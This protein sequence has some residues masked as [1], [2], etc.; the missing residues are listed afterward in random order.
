MVETDNRQ[1]ADGRHA[2]LLIVDD[3][4]AN[5]Q[6]LRVTLE[7]KGF[8]VTG[9]TDPD[10]ALEAITLGAFD[11]LLT[12]LKMP[13]TTGVELLQRAHERDPYLAGIVMTGEGSIASAVE[14]MRSGAVDYVLK[15]LKLSNLLPV[16]A[17]AL[18]LGRLRRENGQLEQSVRARTA[19]LERALEEVDRQAAERLK[20][21]QALMQAQKI[22]A[23]GRLT[24]GVAHDFNNLLA[25]VIGNLELLQRK[26]EPEAPY[27]RFVDNALEAANRGAKVTG[28]L[29]AFSRTQRLRLEPLE[30]DATLQRS[31]PLLRQA[32]GPGVD[33]EVELEAQGAWADTDATQ[34]ELAALNLIVNAREAL[35]EGGVVRLST[36]LQ[37]DWIV[38][39]V[40]DTGVGMTPEV[41]ARAT[42]PFFTTRTGSGTG[43][44]LAQVH[45]FARQCGGD[46]EI[47]SAPGA[48]TRV[49]ISLPRGSAPALI[50]EP[51]PPPIAIRREGLKVLVVDDDRQVRE[52]LCEALISEGFFVRSAAD[53]L[54]GLAQ[55]ETEVP[56]AVVLDYAMPGMTG[57]EVARR[58]QAAHP[59]L[60]IVFLS[61]YADSLALD[62][63]E[64]AAVL[65]KPIA[66]SDLSRAVRLAVG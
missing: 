43:L 31:D 33:L 10:Q 15:P 39:E 14:S 46:C 19:E 49:R 45:G 55:L 21:E 5:L 9:F 36:R 64:A 12:D 4:A 47:E 65:R 63:I 56:D 62:Q 51:S 23:I 53:G 34:L 58:A 6:A 32:L 48:G 52:S 18:T 25:A 42:E 61:G 59:H 30:I 16:L 11:V 24:G 28:Q 22:E 35:A 44:G 57:A 8:D 27:R 66:I 13:S 37:G 20:A 26:I 2:R 50:A 40:A 41:L 29:L 60:P 38:L 3:E 7:A 17:S 1:D 54:S